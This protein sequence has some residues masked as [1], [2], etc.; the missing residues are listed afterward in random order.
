MKKITLVLMLSMALFSCSNESKM[1]SEI[2]AYLDKNAKDPK[3]YEFVDLTI[4]DTVTVGEV[5]KQKIE[6]LAIESLE[7]QNTILENETKIL[8][9]KMKSYPEL[10]IE[11]N[12]QRQA[13]IDSY[14]SFIKANSNDSL[15]LIKKVKDNTLVGYYAKHAYRLKN[16]YGALDLSTSNVAFDKDFKLLDFSDI[17][18][19]SVFNKK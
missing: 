6:S 3:S 14:K 10:F 18:N 16:G 12:K 8:E 1:K 5:A 7:I 4:F 2:K 17:L 9:N 13:S 15:R 11:V 19:Y